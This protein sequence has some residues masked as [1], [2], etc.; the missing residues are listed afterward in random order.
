[1]SMGC[2]R[3]AQFAAWGGHCVIIDYALC[4]YNDSCDYHNVHYVTKPGSAQ[5]ILQLGATGS[6]FV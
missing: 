5:P 3:P 6:G 4:F 2:S 1:M